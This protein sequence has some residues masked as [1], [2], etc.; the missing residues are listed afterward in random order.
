[1]SDKEITR[2]EDNE[3]VED[4]NN[5]KRINLAYMNTGRELAEE[6]AW[7]EVYD[8]FNDYKD[9]FREKLE[10]KKYEDVKSLFD[11]MGGKLCEKHLKSMYADAQGPP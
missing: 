4:P 8:I 1:M 9:K 3:E 2:T 7:R 11:E 6:S 5:R 10:E